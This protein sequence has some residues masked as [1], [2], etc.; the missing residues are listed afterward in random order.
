MQSDEIMLK[1]IYKNA[2]MGRNTLQQIIDVV[3][4]NDLQYELK[5][6]YEQYKAIYNIA[7]ERLRALNERAKGVPKFK[8]LMTS[9]AV[10]MNLAN[11]KTGSHIAEMVIQGS[12]MGMIDVIRQI[13]NYPTV[14]Q[15]NK[16]LAQR[17]LVL[18]EGSITSLKQYL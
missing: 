16:A 14:T 18:E 11:D 7:A 12:T 1:L 5:R 4:D 6:E 9:T 15:E 2:E 17:L 13:K 10:K 8:K 3:K